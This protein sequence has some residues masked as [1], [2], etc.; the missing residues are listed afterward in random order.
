MGQKSIL[1][2]ILLLAL[3]AGKSSAQSFHFDDTLTILVKT[4]D[5]S[6]AHWYIEVFNDVGVDTNLRWKANLVNIPA[7][8]VI[9][10]DDQDNYYSNV[11][12]GDSADFNLMSGLSFPQKLIIGAT[13][14]GTTG[15]GSV[16]FDVYDPNIPSEITTIEYRFEITKAPTGIEE[17]EFLGNTFITGSSIQFDPLLLNK[18]YRLYSLSGQ[19]I[20]SGIVNESRLKLKSKGNYLLQVFVEGNVYSKTYANY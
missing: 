13:L 1:I 7:P 11:L 18:E 16:F 2:I 19:L 5:Q 3:G 20:K 9:S 12:S 14:N 4:T 17:T 6:P 10:F 8:W 15:V